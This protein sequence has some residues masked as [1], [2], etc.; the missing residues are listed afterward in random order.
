ME[1]SSDTYVQINSSAKRPKTNRPISQL[2]PSRVSLSIC[3]ANDQRN[4]QRVVLD[5]LCQ[6]S[7]GQDQV[8]TVG[9]LVAH[10]GTFFFVLSLSPA[11]PLDLTLRVYI[12]N[13]SV[14]TSN[15]STSCVSGAHGDVLNVH[16]EAL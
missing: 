9:E 14:C 5:L 8:V 1:G 2:I 7:N 15:M 13:V 12:H 4:R 3:N 16:T 11:L 10:V 6:T